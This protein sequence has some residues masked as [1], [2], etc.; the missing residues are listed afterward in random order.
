MCSVVVRMQVWERSPMT[1]GC[2][3]TASAG[4]I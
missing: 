4:G 3:E 2:N 1:D